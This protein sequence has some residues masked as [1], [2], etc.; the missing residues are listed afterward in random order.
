[1]SRIGRLPVAMGD[2][3]KATYSGR[4]LEV[5][6]PLGTLTFE[7]PPPIDV[8][9][10]D[11]E[12][13]IQVTRPNDEKPSR[14]LHGLVRALTFNMVK[15]VSDGFER[16]LEIVGVGYNCK[17]PGEQLVLNVGYSHPVHMAVPEGLSVECPGP[18]EIVIKGVDKQRVGQF[19]AEVRDVRPPEP[20]KGKGI[21]YAG[22]HVRR[23]KGKAFV[24]GG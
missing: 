5:S 18:L 12:R 22:E 8:A 2:R 21:R 16:R 13:R 23:K 14:A 9:I 6:G 3:V 20:Y 10:D 15:G 4:T 7:V 17:A 24:S 1:M 11:D 19:A